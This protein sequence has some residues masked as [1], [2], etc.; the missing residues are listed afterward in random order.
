MRRTVLLAVFAAA[1]LCRAQ[2]GVLVGLGDSLTEGVQSANSSVVSQ[3]RSYLT[4]FAGQSGDVFTLPLIG[5]GPLGN[6]EIT[7]DRS[8]LKPMAPATNLAVSGATTEDVLA[9]VA[10]PGGPSEID[11]VLPPYYGLSQIQI[12][13]QL[14]PQ[15]IVCWIGANDLIGYVED[16]NHLDD[17]SFTPLTTFTSEFQTLISDLQATGAQVVIGNIPDL[18]KIAYLFDNTLLQR[19]AGSQYSLPP[20]YYTTLPTAILLRLGIY[21]ADKLTNPAYVLSPDQITNIQ[22]QVQTYNQV[23]SQAAAA[24]GYPLADAYSLLESLAANP[25]VVD[26]ATITPTFNGGGF[27]LDGIHPSDFGHAL[28]ANLFIQAYNAGYSANVPVLSPATL[29]AIAKSD[30]FID[31]NGNG[32]VRGRPFTGLLESIGPFVGISGDLTDRP[33]AGQ[34][35]AAPTPSDASAAVKGI[36]R[37][38]YQ[39]K[40]MNPDTPFNN[41]DVEQ[42]FL[43]LFHSGH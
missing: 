9:S 43:N 1:S 18:T 36:M 26:G 39:S 42:V 35:A 2:N 23:I 7:I 6:V 20:G 31:W 16:F 29:T 4:L 12:A 32:V 27:S 24:A 22:Q 3:P 8:R 30:P 13:Q 34:S 40:G 38:Y 37:L 5:S 10:T 33:P 17:P 11:L 25:I 21:G 15:T 41:S 28:F 19:Y 14:H